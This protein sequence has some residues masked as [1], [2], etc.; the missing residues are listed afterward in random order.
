MN[1]S[2]LGPKL[3][4]KEWCTA[5][6]EGSTAVRQNGKLV[7]YNYA[8]LGRSM[9]VNCNRYHKYS[10]SGRVRFKVASGPY[11]DGSSSKSK[12]YILFPYR[13]IAADRYRFPLG[14]LLYIPEAKGI[15]INLK[16]GK[17]FTHDG[18]F[19]VGDRGGAVAGSH[20]D[21]FQGFEPV[22][23]FGKIAKSTSSRKFKAYEVNNERIRRLLERAHMKSSG[24]LKSG[25]Y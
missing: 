4:T 24:L 10:Q 21:F 13:T 15:K 16:S 5:A 6:L 14:T 1:G 22:P 8:G 12:K 19:L 18:Y 11:G 20:I 2:Y 3:T 25:D 7:T 17:Q 23:G 9:Q